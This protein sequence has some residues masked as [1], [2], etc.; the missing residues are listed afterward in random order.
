LRYVFITKIEWLGVRTAAHY[1]GYE[2]I[3]DPIPHCERLHDLSLEGH[4]VWEISQENLQD[5]FLRLIQVV[6]SM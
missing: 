1:F 4:T 5:A 3:A 6:E 2:R